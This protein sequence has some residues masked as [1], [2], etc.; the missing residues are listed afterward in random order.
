MIGEK[1]GD[2]PFDYSRMARSS[3][4]ALGGAV[5][6]FPVVLFLPRER[7]TEEAWY[8]RCVEEGN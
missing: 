3:P 8:A 4:R 2:E 1:E 7:R 5:G 6:S